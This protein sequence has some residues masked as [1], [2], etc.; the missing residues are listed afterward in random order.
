MSLLK[1]ENS[2]AL[3]RGN[4][5]NSLQST[6]PRTERGKSQVSRNAAK[7]HV[8]AQVTAL[9]MKELG[10][11]PADFAQLRK[12]LAEAM[13]PC[14]P[15]EAAWVEDIAIL[16][17]RLLRLQRAEAGAMAWRQRKLVIERR[18]KALHEGG[19]RDMQQRPLIA[20]A[21]YSGLP[22]SSE[23]FALLLQTLRYLREAVE[24]AGFDKTDLACFDLLYGKSAG[25]QGALLKKSFERLLQPQETSDPDSPERNKQSF[26]TDLAKEIATYEQ[27]QELY[28]EEQIEASDFQRAAELL[29]PAE[30]LDKI[31]RYEAHLENQIERKLRQFYARR[32]EPMLRAGEG[33]RSLHR[34]PAGR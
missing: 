32:R 17:W 31:V 13:E 23:K 5:A 20:L 12:D 2:L 6:G 22:D 11:D 24:R 25:L 8:W 4:R 21:G 27:L 14:D 18:R 30:E 1:R 3:R 34:L 16:R 29:P 19:L 33:S 9:S 26:L 15:F 10:E 7:H 28:T